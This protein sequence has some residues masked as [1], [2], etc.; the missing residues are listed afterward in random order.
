MRAGKGADFLSYLSPYRKQVADS[1]GRSKLRR[2]TFA[3]HRLHKNSRR[4]NSL[5]FKLMCITIY[6]GPVKDFGQRRGGPFFLASF[7]VEL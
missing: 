5:I 2:V 3:V 6:K 7:F 1:A 4:W